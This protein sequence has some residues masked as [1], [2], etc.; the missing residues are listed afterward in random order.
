MTTKQSRLLPFATIL[1]LLPDFAI[2]NSGKQHSLSGPPGVGEL[3]R[4][5]PCAIALGKRR[6]DGPIFVNVSPFQVFSAKFNL[7]EAILLF[8]NSV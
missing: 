6:T 8:H 7:V 1:K 2:Q 4:S 5:H 3:W